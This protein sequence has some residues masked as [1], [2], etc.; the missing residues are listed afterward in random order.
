M[1]NYSN[2]FKNIALPSW[3]YYRELEDE[4]LGM[5]R[6]V[7]LEEGNFSTYSIEISKL[8]QLT[9][10][11]IDTI[12]KILAIQYEPDLN[13]KELLSINRWWYFIQDEINYRSLEFFDYEGKRTKGISA[14]D[15]NLR[16]LN[17]INFEP[18][19][20]F[21]IVKQS[22]KNNSIHYN[23]D[24]NCKH[25]KW[26]TE[27]NHLKHSR[28][29]TSSNFTKS[30]FELANLKNLIHAIGALFILEDALLYTIGS[31]DDL[32]F[33]LG[34]SKLFLDSITGLAGPRVINGGLHLPGM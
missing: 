31:D 30:N 14:N 10:S 22:Y 19:K 11:E 23:L 12:G 28:I 2:N 6:Y 33:F 21:R 18:W 32:L 29:T 26:W 9:C 20:N 1:N 15:A 3:D 27:Y 8:F 17:T 34:S 13:S 4:L 16:F 7:A 25:P 5:R 24:N